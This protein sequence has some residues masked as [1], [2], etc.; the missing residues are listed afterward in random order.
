MADKRDLTGSFNNAK[1]PSQKEVNDFNYAA[2]VGDDAA[3]GEFLKAYPAA[4]D[5][6]ADNGLTA[7]MFA[8]ANGNRSTVALLLKSGANPDEKTEYGRAVQ[9]YAE[10][11]GQREIVAMLRQ[12]SRNRKKIPVVDEKKPAAPEVNNLNY[13]AR[14][15]DDAAVE[16]FLQAHPHI[17]DA[18]A[19]NGLT[20]LMAAAANGNKSTVALLLKKGANPDAKTLEGR[21]ATKFAEREGQRKIITMLKEASKEWARES[22]AAKKGLRPGK[23]L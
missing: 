8:A 18:R 14:I 13:A 19:D 17:I 20:A 16:K 15:G 12:A 4:V 11:E 5:A 3:V 9:Q 1:K 21:T 10:R 22:A 6:K 23:G 7:L 2:R